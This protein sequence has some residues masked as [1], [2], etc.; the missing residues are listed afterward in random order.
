M[1]RLEGKVLL[2]AGGGGIGGGIARRFAEEGA[3]VVL[4]DVD[5]QG[6][7]AIVDDIR[8]KGGTAIAVALDGG[9]EQSVQA[10]VAQACETFG[11]LDGMHVNFA[12]F[13]DWSL[14]LTVLDLPIEAYDNVM[15]VN[16]RGYMLCTRAALPRI[17]ERGGG[18]IAY[19]GSAAA[20]IG[21][22]GR[23]AY[24]MSKAALGGLMRHVAARFGPRNV[25]CNI[26]APGQVR[27]A[28]W[29]GELTPAQ[30]DSANYRHVKRPGEPTDIAAMSAL[31]MSDEGSFITAQI[32]NVDGGRTMRA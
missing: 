16:A 26:V 13:D 9:E 24:G 12:C 22:V 21:E 29:G 17:L 30:A 10:A 15:R 6:A 19:T 14:D 1:R 4:G 5:P 2:V 11:G 32:L 28:K 31:L 23:V 25:R 18:S 27:S 3:S 7:G 8:G 20:H